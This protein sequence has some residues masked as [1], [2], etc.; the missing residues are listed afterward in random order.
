MSQMPI[1]EETRIPLRTSCTLHYPSGNL[2]AET[3][4]ISQ[5]GVG[6]D[7]PSGSQWLNPATI[8]SISIREIGVFDVSVRWKRGNRIGLSFRSQAPAQQTL[9]A[10]L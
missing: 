10:Y 7:L 2:A 1:E 8:Q 9:D 4:N 6:I 3:F 5:K